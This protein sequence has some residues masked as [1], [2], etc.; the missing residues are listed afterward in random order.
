MSNSEMHQ[1]ELAALQDPFLQDALDGYKEMYENNKLDEVLAIKTAAETYKPPVIQK[2]VYP[3]IPIW[4]R[5]AVQVAVAASIVAGT[6]WYI[7]NV[8][9]R[10]Q[11]LQRTT[12]TVPAEVVKADTAADHTVAVQPAPGP[13]PLAPAVTSNE[14]LAKKAKKPVAPGENKPVIVAETPAAAPAGLALA[15]S[16]TLSDAAPE[17]NTTATSTA[18]ALQAPASGIR[19]DSAAAR[20]LPQHIVVGKVV[21]KEKYPLDNI[22]VQVKG[23]ATGVISDELGR[24]E[25]PAPEGATLIAS[26]PGFKPKEFTALAGNKKMELEL[27]AAPK[28]LEEVVVSGYAARSQA[29][30]SKAL[31]IDTIEAAPE[32]GWKN[33][34][35]FV[36]RNKK[37]SAKAKAPIM[38][39]LSFEVDADGRPAEFDIIES[40]GDTYDDEAIRLLKEGPKWINKTKGSSPMA[41]ITITF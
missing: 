41:K 31:Q 16:E 11:N 37:I 8:L 27:E 6:G 30:K 25:I 10:G 14:Q 35:D 33:F 17:K 7:F 13:G 9:Q 19:P 32:G 18:R 28:S 15:D 3:P 4:R 29:K 38:V 23:T 36:Q 39:V 24:F 40:A 26:G 21:D 20:S 22:S 34:E 1:F 5:K 12:V 2:D